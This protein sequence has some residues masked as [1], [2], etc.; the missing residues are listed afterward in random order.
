MGNYMNHI[1]IFLGIIFFSFSQVIPCQHM[2]WG[3]LRGGMKRNGM[4]RYTI[5][6]FSHA[7]P[8]YGYPTFRQKAP[9]FFENTCT[10]IYGPANKYKKKIPRRQI[11]F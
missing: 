8:C 3:K 11:L 10:N 9:V 4:F 2:S 5:S 7:I 6:L 1:G